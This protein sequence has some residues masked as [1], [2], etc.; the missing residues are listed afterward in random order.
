MLCITNKYQILPTGDTASNL[1]N[2][3]DE[4]MRHQPTLRSDTMSAI[5][6]LLQKL[7]VLGS[8]PNTVCSRSVHRNFFVFPPQ[9]HK[10]SLKIMKRVGKSAV[11]IS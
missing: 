8:D 6:A 10:N 7:Y 1:G 4:L 5:S 9:N 3:M 11:V 2:A